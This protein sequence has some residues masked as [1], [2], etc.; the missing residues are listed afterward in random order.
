[1]GWPWGTREGR[2]GAEGE[3]ADPAPSAGLDLTVILRTDGASKGPER[4]RTLCRL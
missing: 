2:A 3:K 1:M 4:T